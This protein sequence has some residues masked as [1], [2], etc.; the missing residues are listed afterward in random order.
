MNETLNNNTLRDLFKFINN[1]EEKNSGMWIDEYGCTIVLF[2]N[3]LIYEVLTKETESFWIVSPLIKNTKYSQLLKDIP[4]ENKVIKNITYIISLGAAKEHNKAKEFLLNLYQDNNNNK[5]LITI[6]FP[7]SNDSFCT[8]RSTPLFGEIRIPS[9]ETLYP[10]KIIIDLELLSFVNEQLNK[11]GI[12][13]VIGLYYSL[14]DY[15][16]VNKLRLPHKIIAY[17]GNKVR[18]LA[19]SLKQ[20]KNTWLKKLA[21]CL[22]MKCFIMRIARTNRVGAAG[23]HLISYA[24]N[25]YNKERAKSESHELSHGEAVFLGS[26]AMNAIFP[27]IEDDNFFNL[28]TL[29]E[30]GLTNGIISYESLELL[31]R[32][33]ED[34]D[35][36][37]I[38]L[39][40]RP[41]RPT[42][43][44][45]SS[46]GDLYKA[47]KR[48]KTS[49]PSN[50]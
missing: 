17:V 6:P 14:H 4:L 23:D 10:S 15:Y 21:I 46:P 3:G 50:E 33:M 13:E 5:K 7:L 44:S 12:G 34:K 1:L 48:L 25:I 41:K 39:G 45:N 49:I 27:D 35:F 32:A 30:F 37:K 11:K 22:L 47:V 20:N 2:G 40:V 43:L 9:R 16:L 31:I 42:I 19:A 8:N 36:L 29:I 38:V 26:I 28:K 24:L 18:D